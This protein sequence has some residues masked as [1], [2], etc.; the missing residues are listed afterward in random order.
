M[1]EFLCERE[2]E[3][4]KQRDKEREKER[5]T[6]LSQILQNNSRCLRL[7]FGRG[8]VKGGVKNGDWVKG[9]EE[10]STWDL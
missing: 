3:R 8:G 9:N 4:E 2:R 5:D 10:E 7:D 6:L 1:R